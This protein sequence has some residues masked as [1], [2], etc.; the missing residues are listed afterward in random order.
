VVLDLSFTS[1]GAPP[2]DFP[3]ITSLGFARSKS[4]LANMF[5]CSDR[6]LSS[7][8][9][10]GCLDVDSLSMRGG[11]HWVKWWQQAKA[12]TKSENSHTRY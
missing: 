10:R 9:M 7:R 5:V 12:G 3:R 8:K 1:E 2:A 6:G 4:S 11:A